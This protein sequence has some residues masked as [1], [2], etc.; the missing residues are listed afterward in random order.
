M[1]KDNNVSEIE[2]KRKELMVR[3]L[4]LQDNSNIGN[5][6]NFQAELEEY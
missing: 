5:L 2:L 4:D 1:A 6:E 3:F